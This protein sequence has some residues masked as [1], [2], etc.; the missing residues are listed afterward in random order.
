MTTTVV[1]KTVKLQTLAAGLTDPAARGVVLKK[2]GAIYRSFAQQRFSR[3]SR[4]GG[5]WPD[6]KRATKLARRGARKAER[7]ARKDPTKTPPKAS[8]LIDKGLLFAALAPTAGTGQ[9][10][11]EQVTTKGIRL[12]YGGP[13]KHGD[14]GEVTLADIASFHQMGVGHLPKR[15]IIAE[16]DNVT[17]ALMTRKINEWLITRSS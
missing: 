3:L 4:G 10:A 6:L 2:V 17:L 1:V 15:V 13:M 11:L 7:A 9:G 14:S 5:E 12:G 8:I 16:P